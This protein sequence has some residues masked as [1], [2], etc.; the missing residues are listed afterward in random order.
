MVRILRFWL[1]F[2]RTIFWQET[3]ILRTIDSEQN[4]RLWTLNLRIINKLFSDVIIPKT[5][6]SMISSIM[7]FFIEQKS[8]VSIN[9]LPRRKYQIENIQTFIYSFIYSGG[10]LSAPQ[11]DLILLVE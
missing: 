7:H 3:D 10:K 2:S 11:G 5:F 8:F 9:F 1:K 4:T 6:L